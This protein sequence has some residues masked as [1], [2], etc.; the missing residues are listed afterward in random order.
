[1]FTHDNWII[2]LTQEKQTR[3]TKKYRG[4]YLPKPNITKQTL[5]KFKNV[6]VKKNYKS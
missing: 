5:L 3:T 1:M 6:N 2:K 4:R